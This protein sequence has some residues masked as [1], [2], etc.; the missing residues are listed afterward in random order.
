V[1]ILHVIC[2][3]LYCTLADH[4]YPHAGSCRVPAHI[5]SLLWI[6]RVDYVVRSRQRTREK[7][8]RL[9]SSVFRWEVI[10]PRWCGAE[11]CTARPRMVRA[12]QQLSRWHL[13]RSHNYRYPRNVRAQLEIYYQSKAK[14]AVS[15]SWRYLV[16]VEEKL[17]CFYDCVASVT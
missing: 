17:R 14:G 8:V 16:R 9:R 5:S 7:S 4:K 11:R 3:G 6:C 10:Q 1:V 2:R 13:L 12:V 15:L